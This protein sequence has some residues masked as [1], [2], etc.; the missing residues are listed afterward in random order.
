MKSILEKA[1][2]ID[3]NNMLNLLKKFPE[4]LEE[5]YALY[6][7]VLLP[8]K[9]NLGD[10][11]ISLQPSNIIIVGMGGSAIGGLLLQ[12]YFYDKINKP[13]F[14][15]KSFEL[16]AYVSS[17]TLL[18]AVSYSG[19]T[20]ETL[21]AV[22]IG[23]KRGA[24]I[25]TVS[26]GGWLMKIAGKYGLPHI[27]L[28]SGRPPRTALPYMINALL[29]IMDKAGIHSFPRADVRNAISFIKKKVNEYSHLDLNSLPGV[30]ASLAYNNILTIYSY[31]PYIAAGYRFKTQINEN[32][33][34]HAFFAE[35]PEADHNEIMGWEKLR[36]GIAACMIRGREERYYIKPRIDFWIKMFQEKGI[37]FIEV[38]AEGDNLFSELIFLIVTFDFASYILSIMKNIDPYP[39]K[40]ISELK[41]FT[42]E[43]IRFEEELR[44]LI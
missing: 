42:S 11:D 17:S 13:L 35:L 40:T 15:V 21:R 29:W 20:E 41:R 10:K 26:S 33:K 25:V 19:N 37:P 44:D 18:I 14:T 5:A 43:R 16:P 34:M 24:Y 39:V 31:R 8:D 28:P 7:D 36:T 23:I 9:I 22:L 2:E 30:I 4:D 12:D 6:S 1:K 38:T 27:R 32:A 3:K